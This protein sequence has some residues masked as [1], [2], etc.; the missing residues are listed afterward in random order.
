MVERDI[1]VDSLSIEEIQRHKGREWPNFIVCRD[2]NARISQVNEYI[3]LDNGHHIETL[4][5]NYVV[6]FNLP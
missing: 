1:S 4:P 3:V 2:L 6:N 5:N